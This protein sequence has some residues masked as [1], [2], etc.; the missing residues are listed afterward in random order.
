MLNKLVAI[1][2]V[3]AGIASIAVSAYWAALD[4]AALVEANQLLKARERVGSSREIE[5][6]MHRE[7]AHRLNVGFEGIWMGLGGIL[8]AVGY[9]V[10]RK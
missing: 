1:V 8:T 4:Y 3:N 5:L 7:T 2:I 10:G 9:T 6:I